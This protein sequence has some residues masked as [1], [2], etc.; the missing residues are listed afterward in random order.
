MSYERDKEI[1]THRIGVDPENLTINA[2]APEYHLVVNPE[3]LRLDAVDIIGG[4]IP[5][6]G[7]GYD[8]SLWMWEATSPMAWED[9]G[10][11]E[12]DE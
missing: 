1:E 8:S 4:K 6:S 7:D 12:M 3:T 9:G 10:L 11:M 5:G 2:G